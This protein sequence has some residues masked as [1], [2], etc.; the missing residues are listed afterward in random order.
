[1]QQTANL[2]AASWAHTISSVG[3]LSS[4]GHK[5]GHQSVDNLLASQFGKLLTQLLHIWLRKITMSEDNTVRAT[6]ANSR[7]TGH[8]CS[9]CSSGQKQKQLENKREREDYR[10]E[11]WHCHF[12]TVVAWEW[13]CMVYIILEVKEDATPNTILKA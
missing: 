9:H 10:R 8:D 4:A 5:L 1:M 11:N 3:F 13:T 2:T 7:C 6:G 12:V